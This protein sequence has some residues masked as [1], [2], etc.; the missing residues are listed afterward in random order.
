MLHFAKGRSPGKMLKTLA[1]GRLPGAK[2]RA[3]LL[4]ANELARA[5]APGK[6]A[7]DTN[8]GVTPDKMC[9]MHACFF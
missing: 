3:N 9:H 2:S 5:L 8:S 1:T 4:I 7:P 6:C